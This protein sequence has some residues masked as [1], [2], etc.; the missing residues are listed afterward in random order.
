[1]NK[2]LVF[3]LFILANLFSAV[4]F[5]FSVS[6][7]PYGLIIVLLYFVFT[8][9][10]K[11]G[12]RKPFLTISLFVAIY[13]VLSVLMIFIN[14]ALQVTA[15]ENIALCV[16]YFSY[17]LFFIQ[18][19]FY[20]I[21]IGTMIGFLPITLY[22]I[23]IE[24]PLYFFQKP[25]LFSFREAIGLRNTYVSPPL[26]FFIEGSQAP[27]AYILLIQNISIFAILKR[28]FS[29]NFIRKP[30][31]KFFLFC[32][33]V[34]AL[35]HISGMQ[36]ISFWFPLLLFIASI[37]VL[38][39]VSSDS[40]F[41]RL[42]KKVSIKTIFS[43]ITFISSSFLWL[44][45]LIDKFTTS[46][47]IDHSASSRFLSFF[48]GLYDA[49]HN[50]FM[51]LGIAEFKVSRLES[52]AHILNN[53]SLSAI[54]GWLLRASSLGVISDDA[55]TYSLVGYFFSETGFLAIL[56]FTPFFTNFFKT[57]SITIIHTKHSNNSLS[58]K[59]AMICA[60]GAPTM[61][62]FNMCLGYPRV[63]PYALLS[64]FISWKLIG[65]LSKNDRSHDFNNL[66]STNKV[67]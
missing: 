25:L 4:S 65:Y 44:P 16:A 42:K 21:V 60:L 50:L 2:S 11:L 6:N 27:A 15:I 47:A 63:M 9:K 41:L 3:G 5:G 23:F 40:A 30:L 46:Y 58:F 52:L 32:E 10:V 48:T 67:T 31:F 28:Y 53:D 1:M 18:F 33:L 61:Y 26:A 56:F 43:V 51:P 57:L 35:S 38:Q 64:L 17:I 37:T 59:L 19:S 13:S 22:S 66:I 20:E 45:Y 54:H 55:A 62:L 34:V 29:S 24:L 7:Y 12:I 14:P 36:F 8:R 39:L 49:M